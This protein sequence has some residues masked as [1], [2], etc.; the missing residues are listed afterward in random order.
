M[1]SF[2][3]AL[4][5][6]C[7]VEST[8]EAFDPKWSHIWSLPI[9]QHIRMFLWLVRQRPMKNVE[10]VRRGFSSDPSCLSCGRCYETTLHILR[11]YPPTRCLW[12]SIVPQT[13]HIS[14]FASPLEQWF[15]SNFGTSRAIGSGYPPWSCFFF[16][17]SSLVDLE[18]TSFLMMFVFPYWI[19]TRLALP[20]LHILGKLFPSL[21]IEPVVELFKYKASPYG[22][23]C[24]NI[25]ATV[26]LSDSSGSIGVGSEGF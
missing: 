24:L 21:S 4:A 26:S 15:V 25:D 5:Y 8:W 17:F 7:M 9:M 22:W 14:F 23:L 20:E 19:S 2:T 12:Q 16:S 3:I 18:T 6:D 11:D 10:R 13:S 1:G